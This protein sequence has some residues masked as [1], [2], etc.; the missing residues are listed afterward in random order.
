MVY[1]EPKAMLDIFYVMLFECSEEYF[2][3]NIIIDLAV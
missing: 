2:K 3:L 1:C